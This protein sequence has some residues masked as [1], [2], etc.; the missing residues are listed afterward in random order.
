[1]SASPVVMYPVWSSVWSPVEGGRVAA[2]AQRGRQG[3]AREALGYPRDAFVAPVAQR[4]QVE[5]LAGQLPFDDATVGVFSGERRM[6]LGVVA[7]VA[8]PALPSERELIARNSVPVH[9]KPWR[10]P[11]ES[12]RAMRES[13]IPLPSRMFTVSQR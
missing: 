10:I 8:V 5:H 11:S 3:P 9:A 7:V 1:M 2:D 6:H 4:D 12:F 13:I